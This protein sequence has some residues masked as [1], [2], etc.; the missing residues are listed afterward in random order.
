MRGTYRADRHEKRPQFPAERPIMPRWLKGEAR[1]V[2]Q[3]TAPK[4]IEAGVLT[5]LDR[6]VF[7]AYCEATAD[8]LKVQRLC[9][10]LAEQDSVGQG[11][12]IRTKKGNLVQNPLIGIRNRA[13]SAMTKLAME[14]GLTPSSKA[15]VSRSKPAIKSSK[16]DPHRFFKPGA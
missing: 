16:K 7:A 11:L 3:R 12:L 15:R 10:Q 1:K 5:K 9:E 6:A 8:Y 2:W 13:R 4:L 14:F